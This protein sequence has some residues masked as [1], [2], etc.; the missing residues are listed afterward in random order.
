M[1]LHVADNLIFTSLHSFCKTGPD[2]NDALFQENQRLRDTIDDL[3][4][5]TPVYHNAQKVLKFRHSYKTSE[6]KLYHSGY[7]CMGVPPKMFIVGF[8]FLCVSC[9]F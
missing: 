3:R 7:L 6:I 4:V 2:P 9:I 5:R 1:Q 8:C